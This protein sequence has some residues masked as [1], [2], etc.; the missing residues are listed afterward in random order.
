MDEDFQLE[1]YLE[2]CR[3]CFRII[4]DKKIEIDETIE[5]RFFELTSIELVNR[6]NFNFCK[7]KILKSL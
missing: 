3:C 6:V 4:F 7:L 2:K 1:N 5:R